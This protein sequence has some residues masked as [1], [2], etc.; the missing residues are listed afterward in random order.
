MIS[1]PF[2]LMAIAPVAILS[3]LSPTSK[4]AEGAVAPEF[5]P[6]TSGHDSHNHLRHLLPRF[7]GTVG[8]QEEEEEDK[9][10]ELLRRFL[11]GSVKDEDKQK[12]NELHRKLAY[13]FTPCTSGIMCGDV[14]GTLTRTDL[15][16]TIDTALTDYLGFSSV[17]GFWAWFACSSADRPD[18]CCSNYAISGIK[19]KCER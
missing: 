14:L 4:T 12:L 6:A 15:I 2:L 17:C 10:E 19:G 1:M 13:T 18:G 5:I 9:V 7:S 8:D 11:R 16:S 3:S